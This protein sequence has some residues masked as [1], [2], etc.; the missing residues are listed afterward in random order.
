MAGLN[1]LSTPRLQLE[2]L[3]PRHAEVLFAGLQN[4]KLYDW[5]EDRPPE[6]LAFLRQRYEGLALR[7]SPD[8]REIWLNWAIRHYGGGYAG[9]VQATVN[10]REAH[11]AYVVFADS[12]G[13]GIGRETVATIINELSRNYGVSGLAANVDRRNLRSVRLLEALGFRQHSSSE[14]ASHE[15]LYRRSLVSIL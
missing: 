10:G 13:Q 11:I 7:R 6:S 9:Y 15:L 1:L 3:E 4:E 8:G 12:W 2:P 14:A 5:I